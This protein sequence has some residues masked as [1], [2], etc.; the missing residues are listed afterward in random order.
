M[1]LR[2]LGHA[3]AEELT[4]RPGWG[5]GRRGAAPTPGQLVPTRDR[6]ACPQPSDCPRGRHVALR[7]PPRRH[8]PDHRR[9]R[10][11][12]AGARPATRVGRRLPGGRVADAQAGHADDR[13]RPA[14]LPAVVRRRRPDQRARVRGAVAYAVAD[15]LGYPQDTVD[16]GPGAVQRGDPARARSPSTSTSTEF[17]ITEERKQAVD[18]SSPYYDVKQAVMTRRTSSR[19]AGATTLAE[20]KAAKLGAQVGT[21][22]YDAITD[23]IAPTTPAVGVQHQRRRQARA[24]QRPGRRDRGRPARPRSTS[25]RPSWTDGKIVGQLPLAPARPSSSA[26]LDKGSPLTACVTRGRRRAARRRHARRARDSSGCRGGRRARAAVTPTD[27]RRHCRTARSER[28]RA[29]AARLPALAGAGARRWSRSR[30]TL[31][32]ARGRRRSAIT[33][34]P[35]WPRVQDDVLRPR[36]GLASLPP[37]LDGLWLNIRVLVVARSGSWCSGL[38]IALAAHPARPGLLPAA[39]PGHG[40]RRPVPRRPADHRAL[41]DRLRGAGAAAAGRADRVAVLGTVALILIYSAYVA[42]VFRAGSSRCTPAARRGP[43]ARA[44]PPAD[45]A[46]GGAARRPSAGCRR[47][48]STTSSRC[49]RTSG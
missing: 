33:H 21:T 2:P 24:D 46:A 48:C 42:E 32:F 29:G 28:A 36:R 8:P 22:S 11:R 40:L 19:S 10:P 7:L 27:R 34:A 26:V 23:L 14:G 41:P 31:V 1:L 49:R 45:H 18:F 38:L 35:G 3:T 20:L 15:E 39:G 12:P 30:R 25:P 16:L 37:V 4:R 47:R 13:H 43:L 6:R 5:C 17:S 44:D 9:V